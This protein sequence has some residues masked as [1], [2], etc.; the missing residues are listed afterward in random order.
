MSTCTRV[1]TIKIIDE[2]CFYIGLKC[3]SK[4]VCIKV[5]L[6][7]RIES[8]IILR[9]CIIWIAST[10]FCLSIHDKHFLK[11]STTSEFETIFSSW[12]SSSSSSLL[13]SSKENC[14]TT[15]SKICSSDNCGE[16]GSSFSTLSQ[17]STSE[18]ERPSRLATEQ[19]SCPSATKL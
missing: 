5:K 14:P 18:E 9:S 1:L 11:H 16:V 7:M 2:K 12:P 10:L 17:S 8:S 6:C 19:N 3:W 13:S 15:L 4:L